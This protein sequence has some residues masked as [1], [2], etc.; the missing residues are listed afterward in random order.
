MFRFYSGAPFTYSFLCRSLCRTRQ[1]VRQACGQPAQ[2]SR[3]VGKDLEYD[4]IVLND[5][6]LFNKR[7]IF[8]DG[9][10][11]HTVYV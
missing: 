6:K 4:L 5:W 7:Y 8:N 1:V 11:L 3:D 2:T 9:D 10:F